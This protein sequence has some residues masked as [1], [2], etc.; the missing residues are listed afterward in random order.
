M[1]SDVSKE[2]NMLEATLRRAEFEETLA[3]TELLHEVS[4][5]V[6]HGNNIES[7]YKRIAEVAAIIM[8]SQFSTIQLLH[9]DGETIGKLR[10]TAATGFTPEAEEYWK[11]IYEHSFS[12]CGEVLRRGQRVIIPD[13]SIEPFMQG[14]PTLQVF[15]DG[16]LHAAQSTPLFSRSGKLLGL[17]STHWSY[18]HTPSQQQLRLL[19]LLAR[20]TA[21]L[22]ERESFM[23]E[24]D[25]R[26]EERT[27]ELKQLNES[28]QQFAHVASHDLKEPVRKIKTFGLR[29]KE[30]LSG[31]NSPESEKY[32]D[33]I[34]ESA[35]RMAT[36]IEGVLMYS[37]LSN[38][39]QTIERL[40][41]NK[42]VAE[43]LNDLELLIQDKGAVVD[44][45]PLQS[46][47]GVEI[48]IYQM[49]YNLI[50][51]SLKF[52][53]A[54]VNPVIQ[55]A[56]GDHVMD[57]THHATIIVRDNGIGFQNE[58]CELIFRT[59]SRLHAK[60]KYDGT[61]LGLALV[62]NIVEIHRGTIEASGRADEGA[63]F[64]IQIPTSLQD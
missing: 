62:K 8:N 41:M 39:K 34:L 28:L 52:S 16:N 53:R 23:T 25:S 24:F 44:C 1:L 18:P 63:T 48:L 11:W 57:G 2:P 20:Q 6:V 45:E 19:D 61:G 3:H 40:D 7:L 54:G 50:N 17:I 21:D 49:F 4:M 46:I 12:S 55:I 30:E 58:H 14:A 43:V 59:F 64:T 33:K 47:E 13:Y 5:M 35:G 9:P 36:M 38:A 60:S 51:N 22:I 32:T 27:A 37:T 31:H 42:I 10:L 15:L 29:L 56:G 26:V